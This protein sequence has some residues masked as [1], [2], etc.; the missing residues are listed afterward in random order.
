MLW[1]IPAWVISC[2]ASFYLG[3]YLKGLAKKIAVVEEAVK[4]KI[5]KPPVVE[6]P[7]S[8]LI[9]PLDPVQEAIYE[10]E[11]LMKRMNP[12]VK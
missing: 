1:I 10:H 2:I 8:T 3:H 11:Q 5:D 7:P 6:D 12:D 4:M 9:D